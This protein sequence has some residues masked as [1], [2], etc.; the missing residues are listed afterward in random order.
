[1]GWEKST[2][3]VIHYPDT[4]YHPLLLAV[5]I[6]GTPA[7]KPSTYQIHIHTPPSIYPETRVVTVICYTSTGS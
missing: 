4:P 5:F 3:C 6:R 1:M 7:L 2:L